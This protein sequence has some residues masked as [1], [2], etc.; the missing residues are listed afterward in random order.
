MASFSVLII[1]VLTV[2]A[3]IPVFHE[4]QLMSTYEYLALR[5]D[6]RT[7][8]CSSFLFGLTVFM[9]LPIV[10]YLSALVLSACKYLSYTL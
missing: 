3:F 10:V 7:R 8:K 4:L 9:L 6:E 2:V 5:F 1:S